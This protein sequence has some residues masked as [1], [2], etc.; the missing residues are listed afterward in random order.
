M[1]LV[2]SFYVPPGFS[3]KFIKAWEKLE[4]EVHHWEGSRGF[5]LYRV[6]GDNT[7]FVGYA[8]FKPPKDGRPPR[9]AGKVFERY[10][11]DIEDAGVSFTT[12]PIFPVGDM[13]PHH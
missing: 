10:M 13:R 9:K 1:R 11:E 3:H 4:A 8:A 12:T 7:K 2:T 6:L 5:A